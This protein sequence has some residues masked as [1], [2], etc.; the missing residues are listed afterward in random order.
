LCQLSRVIP[1]C[2]PRSEISSLVL[3]SMTLPVGAVTLAGLCGGPFRK[4]SAAF[5]PH[6][7]HISFWKTPWDTPQERW[8]NSTRQSAVFLPHG[9]FSTKM[10]HCRSRDAPPGEGWVLSLTLPLGNCGRCAVFPPHC[11]QQRGHGLRQ[12]P[13]PWLRRFSCHVGNKAVIVREVPLSLKQQQGVGL[14][15]VSCHSASTTAGRLRM[16]AR[17]DPVVRVSLCSS[18]RR[19]QREAQIEI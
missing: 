2:L 16:A 9:C 14:R 19:E 4:T 15:A 13:L 6:N 8:G 10:L 3:C 5:R 12:E 11:E 1:A 17:A 18:L 7:L